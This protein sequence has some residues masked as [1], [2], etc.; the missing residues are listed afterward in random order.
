MATALL[1]TAST[2]GERAALKAEIRW[3]E[4]MWMRIRL[5]YACWGCGVAVASLASGLLSRNSSG[6]ELSDSL[7]CAGLVGAVVT[8]VLGGAAE[9]H[10]RLGSRER[11]SAVLSRP[12]PG[13]RAEILTRLTTERRGPTVTIAIRLIREFGDSAKPASP[14]TLD[15]R[16]ADDK[17]RTLRRA[18]PHCR[19]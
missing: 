17:R 5:A 1:T 15:R 14:A 9:R 18:P 6:W 19:R 4:R 3:A 8:F 13:A 16:G 10:C 12:S 2:S 7:A 11:L